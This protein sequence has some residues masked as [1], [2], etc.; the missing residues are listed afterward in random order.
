MKIDLLSPTKKDEKNPFYYGGM[1]S[2]EHFCNRTN[3]IK[4]LQNDIQ[5]GLNV[6]IYAPRRFGKTSLVLNTLAKTPNIKYI[7]LDLMHISTIDEFI[8]HY[9]NAFARTLPQPTDKIISF[10]KQALHIKPNINVSFDANA[11]PTFSLA[12]QSE[13]KKQSLQEVLDA[14][15]YFAEKGQKIVVIFDEFQEIS[16][17]GMETSLR[18]I[19]QHHTDKI[20]YIFMGSKKSLLE[21]MFLD[22]KRPFYKS[23]KR[24]ELKEIKESAWQEFIQSKFTQ[25]GKEIKTHFI[26]QICAITKGFA[27]YTQQ[28][29]YELFSQTQQ[30]VDE[31]VFK[32]SLRIILEREEDLFETQWDALTLNQKKTLK[33]I[34]QKQGKALYDEAI[35][36]KYELKAPSL[37]ASLKALQEKDLIDKSKEGFYFTDPLF[38]YWLGKML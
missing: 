6:L 32:E 25:K 1:A 22:K 30:E 36:A 18:A 9:F 31:N 34:I 4:E 13:D 5:A 38:E 3:E 14:P 20:A 24:F 17:L 2:K 33:I 19:L 29:A 11:N 16:T 28:F 8:N 15:L 10:F 23:V 12:L 7:F 27:Y 21:Q 26:S 37:Q 35:L